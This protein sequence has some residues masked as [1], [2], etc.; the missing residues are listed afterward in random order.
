M[1]FQKAEMFSS[2][3]HVASIQ[4]RAVPGNK[5]ENIRCLSRM[6]QEASANGARLI[7]LPEMCTTGLTI[8]DR[9]EAGLLAEP[10]PG[11]STEIFSHLALSNRVYLVLGLAEYDLTSTTFYNS[12]VVIDPYGK[13][14]CTYRKIHLF[15]PDFNWAK[16]GNLGYQTVDVEGCKIGLGICFDINFPDYLDFISRN[17][18]RLL[19]FSTNWVADELPFLYWSEMLVNSGY[20]FTAANNWGNEA[21]IVFSGGGVILAPDLSVLA[22]SVTSGNSILYARLDLNFNAAFHD[23]VIQR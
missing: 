20:Y 6:I 2:I 10:F 18:V 13:I 9:V 1:D 17:H 7:V 19:T 4:Y 15:G 23:G 8:D 11:P 12:Q 16:V 22:Q 21:D 5:S 3:I 14:I